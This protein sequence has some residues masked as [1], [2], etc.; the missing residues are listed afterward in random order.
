MKGTVK[1]FDPLKGFGFIMPDRGGEDHFVH[2]SELSE[3]VSLEKGDR[4][5]F[6][7]ERGDRGLQALNVKK[8]D[9]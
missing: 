1:F 8:I 6:E 3:G 7:S 9:R 5:K 2:R 4:V